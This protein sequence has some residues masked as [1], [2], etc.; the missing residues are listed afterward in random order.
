MITTTTSGKQTNK[1]TVGPSHVEDVA[2]R[3][4]Q[5]V[6]AVAGVAVIAEEEHGTKARRLAARVPA[7]QTD[8][9]SMAERALAKADAR[10][11]ELTHR[12]KVCITACHVL[13]KHELT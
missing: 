7:V 10:K 2:F 11:A 3:G 1:V 12:P 6:E 9:K 8:P 5:P 4:Q 13:L